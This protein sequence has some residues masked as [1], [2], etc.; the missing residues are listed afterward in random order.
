MVKDPSVNAGDMGLTQRQEN[1]LKKEM[2]TCSNIPPWKI[3]WTEEPGR[4]QSIGSQKNQTQRLNS[5]NNKAFMTSK[6]VEAEVSDHI[7]A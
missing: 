5:N 3:I 2:T 7:W 1:A 6:V 4:L